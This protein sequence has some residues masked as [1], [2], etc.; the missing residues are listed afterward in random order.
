MQSSDVKI[1]PAAHVNSCTK[2]IANNTVCYRSVNPQTDH[3]RQLAAVHQAFAQSNVQILIK[4]YF[5]PEYLT[6][7][8]T[9]FHT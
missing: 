1:K 5:E 4:T 2:F 8:N 6:S 7:T 9:S 3:W